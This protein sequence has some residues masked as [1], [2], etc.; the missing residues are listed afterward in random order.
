[1]SERGCLLFTCS[2][3]F[4][5]VRLS[6]CKLLS[7]I[8]N[9]CVCVRVKSALKGSGRKRKRR[10]SMQKRQIRTS[11]LQ[12]QMWKRYF[13]T[14]ECSV[15]LGSL[16]NVYIFFLL[17]HGSPAPFLSDPLFCRG[18]DCLNYLLWSC[19]QPCS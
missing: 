7:N 15:F 12:K 2:S 17:R 9:L 5:Q 13:L 1:M 6:F 16:F 18:V 3:V 8:V 11:M 14:P 4:G 10:R 19:A